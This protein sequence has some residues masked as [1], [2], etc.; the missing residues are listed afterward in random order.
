M[1]YKSP[2]WAP[3]IWELGFKQAEDRR[4]EAGDKQIESRYKLYLLFL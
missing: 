1:H 2:E 4:I 3:M